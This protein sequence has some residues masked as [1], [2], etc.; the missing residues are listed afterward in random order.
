MES[1]NEE[2]EAQPEEEEEYTY[3]E[4]GEEYDA[5]EEDEMNTADKVEDFV[6]ESVKLPEGNGHTT[7]PGTEHKKTRL[8][9]GNEKKELRLPSEGNYII[10]E[11]AEIEPIMLSL[12]KEVSSLLELD[13]NVAMCLLQAYKW[14]KERLIDLFFQDSEKICRECGVDLYSAKNWG[15]SP[16]SAT[17]KSPT[18][19]SLKRSSSKS[20]TFTC[21]ICCDEKDL[22]EGTAMGCKHFYCKPCYAEYL[23]IKVTDG[24]VCI[25]TNCP[26]PKCRQKVTRNLFHRLLQRE[27]CARYDNYY[28]R[29]FIEQSKHMKYCPAA[30]CDR[31]AVGSGVVTIRCV[32]A[33]PFCFRC[34]EEA[35]EP[36]S[37][38]QL[39]E[40]TQKCQ[41]ESETANWILA[42]T[43]KCPKC[44]T[45]IE[46]NQ[47]C[48][49]MTCSRCRYEFCWICMGDWKAHG[50]ATGGFYKCN[51]YDA[52]KVDASV[53]A[54][55][56]AKAELDRYLHYYQRYHGHDVSLKF[57][58]AQREQAERRM[59][60]Q[61]EVAKSSWIDVQFLKQA[62]EQVIDCRRV[63]KYTYVLGF[64]LPDKSAEKELFEYHQ[65]MLEKNTDK[66]QEYTEK[67]LD[68]IDSAQVIN[69]T[70][71]TE[72]F[73]A[74][75]LST[76]TG[77]VVSLDETIAST[78]S[79]TSSSAPNSATKAK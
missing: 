67:N 64:A 38:A 13:D 45:R 61:Q 62:T 57:A 1:D 40:W 35:H 54:A 78:L 11:C 14:D 29:N 33:N 44:S 56:K 10:A 5:V 18:A 25:L 77:G 55:E 24:P 46:K 72:K 71:V 4:D 66:L 59:V 58:N 22:S 32:C 19:L 7:A 47:G 20:H 39:A 26:E 3:E 28:V 74:S 75:L 70:R 8:S 50:E 21:K 76:I 42:N 23:R 16:N 69:L 9:S 37:C 41:N 48:N 27:D 52:S 2:Y 60:E 34:G 49:H 65:E 51:R 30:R 17:K 68:T 43:R 31:V 53:T 15:A 63:L 73:M 6:D 12:V 36:C 79:A